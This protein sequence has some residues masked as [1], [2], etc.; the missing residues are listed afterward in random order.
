MIKH[1]HTMPHTLRQAPDFKSTTEYSSGLIAAKGSRYVLALVRILSDVAFL[2]YG[3]HA[4]CAVAVAKSV[5]LDLCFEDSNGEGLSL[6]IIK[7]GVPIILPETVPYI[8]D[9]PITVITPEQL[10]AIVKLC[11]GGL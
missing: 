10:D 2:L 11:E 3:D 5:D 1:D 6:M 9:I 8:N 7:P 4:Y